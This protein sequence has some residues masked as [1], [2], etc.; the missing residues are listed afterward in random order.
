M[1]STNH[2]KFNTIVARN[3]LKRKM[4]KLNEVRVQDKPNEVK[5]QDKPHKVKDLIEE[6]LET[7]EFFLEIE[8]MR[9]NIML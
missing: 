4:M 6:D 5:V 8:R 2:V 9:N 7:H 1:K 3:K